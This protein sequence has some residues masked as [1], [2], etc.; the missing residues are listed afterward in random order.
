VRGLRLLSLS[1]A[2]AVSPAGLPNASG[3]PP[4]HTGGFGEP[5]CQACHAGEALNAA[6]GRLALSGVPERYTPGTAYELVVSLRHPALEAAGF[7]LSARFASGAAL[8]GQAGTLSP[9]AGPMALS[10]DSTRGVEYL[11]HADPGAFMLPGPEARWRVVWRAPE[12]SSAVTFHV[13]ANAANGDNSP[14]GDHIFTVESRSQ[15]PSGR[16]GP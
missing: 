13:A 5:T 3:P 14:L 11:S 12:S 10:R 9:A 1:A 15:P 6:D 16:A 2:A 8:G 7:Q 4:G